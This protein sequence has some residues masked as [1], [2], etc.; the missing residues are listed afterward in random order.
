MEAAA[1]VGDGRILGGA[2]AMVAA[3]AAVASGQVLAVLLLAL[4]VPVGLAVLRRPQRGLLLLAALV[5]F[6]G[7]LLVVPDGGSVAGW[8]EALVL[9]VVVG[10]LVAP[11]EARRPADGRRPGWLPAVAAFA[12]LGLVS[13]LVVG[14]DQGALGAKIGLFYL[15]VAFAA[16]RCPLDGRERDRLVTILMVAGVVTAVYGI[17][18]QLLGAERLHELGYEYNTTIRFAGGYLR[19]FSTFVQPFPFGF[20]LMLVLLLGIPQVLEEPRRVRNQLFA[21]ATPVLALG[22]ASSVVRGAWLGLAVGLL[23]L[24]ATRYRVLL[25]ALPVALVAFAFL[26]AQTTGVALS[27]TSSEERV[28]GWSDNVARLVAHPLGEGIGAVGAPAERVHEERGAPPSTAYQPDNYFVKT[29][30]ELGVLGLWLFTLVLVAALGAAHRAARATG[31]DGPLGAG[32]AAYV[33]AATAASTVSTFFEIFP[34][35]LYFWLLL[36]V[37]TGLTVSVATANDRAPALLRPAPSRALA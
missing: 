33:L 16:W 32:T 8:K 26:P 17:A 10:T 7:L 14:G 4:A 21:V 35:E 34:L 5:P 2:A 9:L 6:D 12:V 1:R 13:A 24:A 36:S 28:T 3:V 19:S 29:G 27:A 25:L 31:R 18:Q 22:L 20:F 37:V 30:I 11:A 15:L 23:Y